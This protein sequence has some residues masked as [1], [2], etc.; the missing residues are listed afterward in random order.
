MTSLI[1]QVYCARLAGLERIEL[2]RVA[3]AP[4][5]IAGLEVDGQHIDIDLMSTRAEFEA[6]TEPLIDR[7]IAIC[8]RVLAAHGV[9][10]VVCGEWFWW[11]VRR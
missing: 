5:F 11:A 10:R 7:S 4:L 6:L 2:T 8:K 9:Q 1:R 3:E